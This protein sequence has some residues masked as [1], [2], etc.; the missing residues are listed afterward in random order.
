[1]K[2]NQEIEES[3]TRTVKRRVEEVL[4]IVD[5]KLINQLLTMD[6]Y[7]LTQAKREL[8]TLWVREAIPG[9]L[10]QIRVK[11]PNWEGGESCCKRPDVLADNHKATVSVELELEIPIGIIEKIKAEAARMVEEAEEARGKVLM[12]FKKDTE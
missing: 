12:E 8:L 4:K 11:G 9:N 2:L 6:D 1:M 5:Q 10:E 3:I 7:Q